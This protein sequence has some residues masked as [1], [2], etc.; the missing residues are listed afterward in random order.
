[1]ADLPGAYWPLN[2]TSGTTAQDFGISPA[3][4]GTYT[5]GFTLGQVGAVDKAPLLDGVSGYVN[6]GALPAK[7]Q[8]AGNFTLEAWVYVGSGVTAPGATVLGE[9]FS[10]DNNVRYSLGFYNGGTNQTTLKPKFGWYN[11]VWREA[12]S[13]DD[14]TPETWHHLVG[15]W[16]GTQLEL[17]VDKVSKATQA[18]VGV[19]PTGIENLYIGRRHDTG[20][21]Q[22]FNGR[23]DEVAMYP[24]ALSGARVV[25]HYDARTSTEAARQFGSEQW[26]VSGSSSPQRQ[27]G[28]L[29]LEAAG[30]NASVQRMFGGL[31]WEVAVSSPADGPHWGME[32]R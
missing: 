10:G 13:A 26:E 19:P 24:F 21:F 5:G 20:S 1:L 17:F 32:L 3:A 15:T 4:N 7:L 25:A 9:A 30:Q 14:I 8:F 27:I 18:T 2:E 28:G 23:I 6:I 12:I 31:L 29:V 16:N 11:G 22:F